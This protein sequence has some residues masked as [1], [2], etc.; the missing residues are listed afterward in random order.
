MWLFGDTLRSGLTPGLVSNSMLVSAGACVSQVIEPRDGPVIPD[1][2]DHLA[3]WPMS[4]VVLRGSTDRLVVLCARIR[5]GTSGGGLDFTFLG[6]SAATFDVAS[7][8]VPQ[9]RGITPITPDNP[10]GT[11][12]NW[13]AAAFTTGKWIY[14]YGSRS[15]GEKGVF[16][17][18]LLVCRVPIDTPRDPTGFRFWDGSTWQAKASRARP[19]LAADHG[20]SQTLS[21]DRL[22][23]SDYVVVS[24]RDGDLGDFAYVWRGSSPT[25]PFT[26]HE[27]FS[28]PSDY[29]SGELQ[30]APLA[31]PEI[32]MADGGLLVSVSRNTTDL[33]RLGAEPSLGVPRFVETKRP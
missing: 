27:A 30:Y 8:G 7:D 9:L 20:V 19:V 25:G 3:Y 26:P 23:S 11:Q 24:K 21:V 32:T 10:S 12:I 4:V 33:A 28:A 31:H 17:R 13:G 18:E 1:P 16:G 15:T 2:G 6:T 22:A 29:P 5:R 14:V